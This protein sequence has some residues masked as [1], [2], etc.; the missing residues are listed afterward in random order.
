[1]LVKNSWNRMCV[2]ILGG[3][4]LAATVQA[5][6]VDRVAAKVNEKI[7]TLSDVEREIKI[8]KL[9]NPDK[10]AKMKLYNPQTLSFF[11]NQSI[12]VVLIENELKKTG[13]QVT[14]K[15]VDAAYKSIMKQN[16]MT[17]KQFTRYLEKNGLTM[18]DYRTV[19]K[20][21]IE[22]IRFFNTNI[23]THISITDDAMKAYYKSHQKRFQGEERVKIAEIFVPISGD[24]PGNERLRRQN[25][26]MKIESDLYKGKSFPAITKAYQS[27]PMVKIINDL[28]W[29]DK[30]SLSKPI[31]K[32]AFRL[33][34]GGVSN[35]IET[36]GG[37]HIIKVLD[38]THVR[39]TSLKKALPEIKQIL[40]R[41]EMGKKIDAWMKE[42]RKHAQIE[43][44]M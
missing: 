36:K 8:F 40:Y 28:G 21:K 5:R 27:N 42:A 15:E 6:I 38:V 18:R 2:V 17:D 24:L 11:L 3:V 23:K 32:E 22:R 16:K 14:D 35:V 20:Q 29:F 43:I 19:L 9:E 10:A 44:M 4:L 12:S 30:K 39:H 13:R 33:K 34:K 7:I 1:M 41:Q 26:I 31:A 25:I 37:F